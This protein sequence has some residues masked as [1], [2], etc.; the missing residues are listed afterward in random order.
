MSE[1]PL[2]T[3]ETGT[4]ASSFE[5][6]T[7]PASSNHRMIVEQREFD[8]Y[9][10]ELESAEA[11]AFDTE[12]VSED[13]Y[14]PDLCLIQVATQDGLVVIDPKPLDSVDRFWQ[15]I[16]EGDH[17]PIVHSG[18]EAHRVGVSRRLPNL[19]PFACPR[20]IIQGRDSNQLAC[21]SVDRRANRLRV[22][23]R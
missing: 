21:S 6:L 20:R 4:R 2:H 13:C 23:G 9:C 10:A 11:I 8:D 16:I 18:R 19:G 14:R 22:D 7:P 12:F 3:P 17:E 1:P 15:V 5:P